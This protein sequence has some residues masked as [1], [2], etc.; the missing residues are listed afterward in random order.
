MLYN[1]YIQLEYFNRIHIEILPEV[2]P[3]RKL[4]AEKFRPLGIN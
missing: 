2:G 4:D 1:S 3:I